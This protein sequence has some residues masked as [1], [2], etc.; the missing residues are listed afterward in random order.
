LV[1]GIGSVHAVCP[2]IGDFD[3]DRTPIRDRRVPGR[4]FH[5]E[6]L[7]DRAVEIE[8]EMNA[9]PAPVLKDLE[10]APACAR[11]IEMDH[12]L[13]DYPRQQRQVPSAAAY[14]F[15]F[16]AGQFLRPR[17]VADGAARSGLFGRLSRR[18]IE[19][20]ESRV[21]AVCVVAAGIGPQHDSRGGVIELPADHDLVAVPRQLFPDLARRLV[22]MRHHA[23]TE[24]QK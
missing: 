18:G 1:E 12:E 23:Q 8:H 20:C 3:A 11:G 10:A 2:D 6:G 24:D 7:V 19:R 16:I 17:S 22:S 4:L 9:K 13:I 15:P 21:H 14:S 5:V